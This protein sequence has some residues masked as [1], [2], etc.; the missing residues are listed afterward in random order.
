[1]FYGFQ[2]FISDFWDFE[3]LAIF[4]VSKM[5]DAFFSFF[6]CFH[7]LKMDKNLKIKKSEKSVKSL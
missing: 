4:G 5:K 3:F 1:M 7:W 6:F 2:N